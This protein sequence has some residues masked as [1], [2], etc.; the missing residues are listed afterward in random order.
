M[1][2]RALWEVD[3]ET[4]A[5]LSAIQKESNNNVCC[6]C[7][8]PSP[9]WASPK[10][11]IF[12]CLS[13]AGIHRGLGVHIS[14]VRSISMDAFKQIEIERMRVGGND[15]WREFFEQHTHT[16]M[17]GISW[18]ATAIADRY[19][20][21]VG[22][23]W[24]QRLT[25]KVEGREYIP[26]A[27][28]LPKV[29]KLGA[30]NANRPVGLEASQGGEC[31]GFG[32]TSTPTRVDARAPMHEMRTDPLGVLTKGLG[33]FAST[34][35]KTTKTVNDGFLRPTAKQIAESDLGRQA[36]AAASQ[37]GRVAQHSAR[38]AQ[39]SLHRFVEGT[40]DETAYRPAPVEESR[41]GFW[42]NFSSLADARAQQHKD[43]QSSHSSI[44][45]S[46]I[47]S[48]SSNMAAAPVSRKDEWDAW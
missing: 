46:A 6:D 8:A 27:E 28:T 5:K 14:F 17:H 9:Q 10:F 29:T 36:Q 42:D 47:K 34:V 25:A 11:G 31:R 13:C 1:V 48:A 22:D 24:K 7:N 45:T 23:E 12:I 30:H 18:G 37:V 16:K 15:N 4:Q 35:T 39:S 19:S 43:Q 26:V 44:G 41:R 21:A 20:G 2:A 40:K 38:N 3:P 32:N 33:W